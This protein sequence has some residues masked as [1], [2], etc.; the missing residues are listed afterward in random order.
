MSDSVTCIAAAGD[1]VYYGSTGGIAKFYDN[2][3]SLE[4]VLS[5]SLEGVSVRDL[6]VRGDTLWIACER[7]VARFV[8]STFGFTMYRIGSSTSLCAHAGAIHVAGANGVERFD[9]GSWVSLGRPDGLV[10]LAVSSGA[11][12]LCCVTAGGA[13]RRDGSSWTNITANL[14]TLFFQKYTIVSGYNILKTIAV[15][16]RG[17]VWVA[18]L[19]AQ[20]N[21]GSYLSAFLSNVVDQ[22][23]ARESLPERDRQAQRRSR[24]G[25]LGKHGILRGLLPLERRAVDDVFKDADSHGRGRVDLFSEQHRVSPRFAG[26]SVVRRLS[27]IS[28]ASRSTTRSSKR[29]TNGSITR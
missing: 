9:G 10:P 16:S 3:H 25:S 12:T 27:A 15:D 14:K 20:I 4:P 7:G 24:A 1:D 23:G 5:D 18:G 2:L 17:T 26:V 22:Q 19:E 8:R 29:T 11:G 21:R 6:L 13:Y 28:T